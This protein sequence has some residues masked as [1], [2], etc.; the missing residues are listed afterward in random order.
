METAKRMRIRTGFLL[1]EDDGQSGSNAKSI[2]VKESEPSDLDR[3][4]SFVLK[5]GGASAY[6]LSAWRRVIES[7]FDHRTCY[8]HA[9]NALGEIVENPGGDTNAFRICSADFLIK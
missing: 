2:I 9:E 3:W 5:C 8:L 1:Q 7:V 4:D 6:H